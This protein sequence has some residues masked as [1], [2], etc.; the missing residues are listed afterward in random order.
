M[1]EFIVVCLSRWQATDSVAM[2][3]MHGMHRRMQDV[4]ASLER[5]D[6]NLLRVLDAVARH[7]HVTRA[8]R[9]LGLSQP[10]T[11]HALARLRAALGDPLFVRGEDGVLLT[12]RAE[13]LARA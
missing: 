11:S 10:A 7:G 13:A 5:L 6:L 4:H 3:P 8:A 1:C 2:F 9:A 12:P